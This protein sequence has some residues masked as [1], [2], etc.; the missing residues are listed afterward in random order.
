MPRRCPWRLGG[1][2]LLVTTGPSRAVGSGTGSATR[3]QRESR[4]P[5]PVS[6]PEAR[7]GSCFEP[8]Q[9]S[10]GS[11]SASLLTPAGSAALP[12]GQPGR[13]WRPRLVWELGLGVLCLG[14]SV[15]LGASCAVP[16]GSRMSHLRL[17]G[18]AVVLCVRVAYLCHGCTVS[19]TRMTHN[20][21]THSTPEG[22][23]LLQGVC[24][25]AVSWVGQ[26]EPLGGDGGSAIVWGFDCISL[27]PAEVDAFSIWIFPV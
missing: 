10:P 18:F 4:R 16:A 8:V 7:V 11:L 9:R 14:C 3:C 1:C 13:M 22:H 12:L 24:P 6:P 19:R 2:V 17:V 21:C 20:L 5:R 23:T 25:G 27:I 26:S 15:L